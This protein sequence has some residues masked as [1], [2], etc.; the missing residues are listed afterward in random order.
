ML[1]L[2]LI[3]SLLHT[4]VV[5]DGLVGGGEVVH[6]WMRKCSIQL[7]LKKKGLYQSRVL[8]SSSKRSASN[9][10]AV[11][12]QQRDDLVR[13]GVQERLDGREIAGQGPGVELQ[14]AGV[15]ELD[16]AVLVVGLGLQEADALAQLRRHRRVLVVCHEDADEGAVVGAD[17]GH[18]AVWPVAQLGVAIA[19]CGSL[20]GGGY[21]DGE[22]GKEG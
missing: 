17:E 20:D 11:G 13:V 19:G 15:A 16:D 4:H 22:E 5:F 14:A 8:K 9:A 2:N 12:Q 1:V 18:V 7:W 21:Q 10:V 6:E 3:L